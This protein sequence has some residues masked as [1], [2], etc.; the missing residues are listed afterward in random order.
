MSPS[1]P[2]DAYPHLNPVIDDEIES[3]LHD[4][5]AREGATLAAAQR[6]PPPPLGSGRPADP[7]AHRRGEPRAFAV[8]WMFYVII[9]VVGSV[10]WVT[11]STDLSPGS[12]SPAARIMLMV[13]AAGALILWPMTRLSQLAPRTPVGPSIL[14][15]VGV[16]IFPLWMVIWPLVFMAGWPLDVVAAIAVMLAAWV[17]LVGGLLALGL[18]NG[19]PSAG[20]SGG[21]VPVVPETP[22][23]QKGL[24]RGMWMTLILAVVTGGTVIWGIAEARGMVGMGGEGPAPARWWAMFSPFSAIP[25][26]AGHGFNGPENPVSAAQWSVIVGVG[27]VGVLIWTGV[28]VKASLASRTRVGAA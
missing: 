5:A 12:Y 21:Q 28:G 1:Q 14:L 13:I 11:R 20:H 15:D 19:A 27:V 8:L 18:G 2:H 7:W 24:G 17:Y 9:A 23:A 16:V 4:P 25:V 22:G 10:E 3:T 26:L 6:M